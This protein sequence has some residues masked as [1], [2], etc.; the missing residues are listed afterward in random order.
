MSIAA[1]IRIVLW[2]IYLAVVAV[3]GILLFAL[4]RPV[5]QG[6]EAYL[7]SFVFGSLALWVTFNKTATLAQKLAHEVLLNVVLV[8]VAF[9]AVSDGTVQI[10]QNAGVVLNCRWSTFLY[11]VGN[12]PTGLCCQF[13]TIWVV[14]RLLI[15]SIEQM[16]T[17][18]NK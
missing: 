11:F 1:T 4:V 8:F 17:T 10:A 18:V 9:G 12:R 14:A 2:L 5:T 7:A 16:S 3:H 6:L 13:L 15:W